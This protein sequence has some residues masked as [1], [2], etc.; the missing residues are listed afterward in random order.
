[1]V[2]TTTSRRV[3]F[4]L[5]A[6][7]LIIIIAGIFTISNL[8][9]EN[10]AGVIFSGLFLV[11]GVGLLIYGMLGWFGQYKLGKAEINFSQSTFRIGDTFTINYDRTT[12]GAVQID[13]FQ[14]QLVFREVATYQQGTD[15]RTVTKDFQIQSFD[16]P[17]GYVNAGHSWH[18]VFE[19][20]I[21]RDGMH[22][23]DVTRNK[24]KWLVKIELAIPK[25]P[26]VMDEFELNVLSEMAR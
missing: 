9:D 23:L 12:K 20:T 22:S 18:E 7:L 19:I 2:S 25:L 24:L 11:G 26:N 16:L 8:S 21:P 1:M 14:V 17:S 4:T 13:A 6:A 15:T 3:G 10:V 5:G